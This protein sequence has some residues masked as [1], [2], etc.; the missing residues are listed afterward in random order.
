M[1]TDWD[2]MKKI[3]PRR[4]LCGRASQP[5][6]INGDLTKPVWQL[7]P[8]SESFVDIGG[9]SR[10]PKFLTRMK[11]LWD[12]QFL[13]V[14]VDLEDPHLWGA[15]TDPHAN[16]QLD[17]SLGL[18]IDPDGDNHH[19][20]EV[21]L[22]VLNVSSEAT[23][24]R[25]PRDGGEAIAGTHLLGMKSAVK[26]S[27][28]LNDPWHDDEGWTLELAIPWSGLAVYNPC[29][30]TPPQAG[31]QWRLNLCRTQWQ[32]LVE[33][34]V[35]RR[36][37]AQPEERWVWSAVGVGDI[38]RP[39][40]WGVIQF[41]SQ[42]AGAKDKFLTDPVAQ[43]RMVLMQIYYL[44]KSWFDKNHRYLEQEELRERLGA[45]GELLERLVLTSRGYEAWVLS[46]S[47]LGPRRRIGITQDSRILQR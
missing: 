39:E 42:P 45:L 6:E 43:G 27:G 20:Y 17:N 21:A 18:L 9:G 28:S 14:G 22:N 23:W 32:H 15:Q 35:Y 24:P 31:D 44:Q 16:V 40:R 37:P 34:G 41:S 26:T 12:D 13:Y 19:Y 2:I 7:A 47:P 11:L 36:D 8:W 30:A 4:Y 3:A 46:P 5:V 10:R 1:K 25:P 29:R 38:H 33:Y